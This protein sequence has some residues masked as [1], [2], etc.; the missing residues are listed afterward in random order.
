MT[1]N[2]PLDS[3]LYGLI[4]SVV[5]PLGALLAFLWIPKKK[6]LAVLMAFGGG[7]LICALAIDLVAE[8]VKKGEFW[9]LALGCVVGGVIYE[10]CNFLLN[11]QG[12]FLRKRSTAKVFIRRKKVREMRRIFNKISHIHFMRHLPHDEVHLLLPIIIR[13]DYKPGDTIIEQGSVGDELFIVEEGEVDLMD[14][15]TGKKIQV[16]KENGIFGEL[17]FLKCEDHP[18]AA[19]AVNYSRIWL[20]HKTHLNNLLEHH[21]RLSSAFS[22]FLK[23][24]IESGVMPVDDPSTHRVEWADSALEH[25]SDPTHDEIKEHGEKHGNAGIAI[26]LGTLL[27]GIPESFVLGASLLG[28]AGVSMSLLAGVVFSNFP[29]S[30]SSSV[31][32]IEN[33]FSKGKIMFL[34]ISLFII[35]GISAWLGNVLFR[36]A[37]PSLFGFVDGLAAGAMLVMTAETMLP[38]AYEKGGAVTGLSTLAGFLSSVLMKVI[39]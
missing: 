23:T 5:L 16:L 22:K 13:K 37:S 27:D 11:S 10:V 4:G 36:D 12:G 18:Y 15:K 7:A 3:L 26:Y 20:I 28:G 17:S 6:I 24:H 8:S 25:V 31:V 39:G 9:P 32:M 34:W 33:K 21:P 29:E 35:S 2:L 38:E 19:V 1:G 30:M 14:T